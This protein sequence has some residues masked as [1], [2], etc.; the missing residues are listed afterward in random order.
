M[1][2]DFFI[3]LNLLPPYLLCLQGVNGKNTEL[4]THLAVHVAVLPNYAL[5]LAGDPNLS[6]K[7]ILATLGRKY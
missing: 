4:A 5:A 7:K 3:Q 2:V 6:N 1:Y